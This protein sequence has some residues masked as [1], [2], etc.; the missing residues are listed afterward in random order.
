MKFLSDFGFWRWV[1]SLLVGGGILWAGVTDEIKQAKLDIN[2][3]K[4]TAKEV[5]V[6]TT[7]IAVIENDI[8]HIKKTSARI[9]SGVESLIR[10]N[11][12]QTRGG[13]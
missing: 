6:H 7:K 3:F 5:Q 2:D 11:R 10:Y 12:R 8:D 1:I 4:T 9:E 13:E